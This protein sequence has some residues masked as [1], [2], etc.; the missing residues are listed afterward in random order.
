MTR[1]TK[2]GVWNVRTLREIGRLRQAV[3]CMKTYDLNIVGMSEVRWSG[4][5]EM[6]TQD[7]GYIFVFWKT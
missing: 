6:T 3:A 5:G 7:G 1:I 4:F 2:V